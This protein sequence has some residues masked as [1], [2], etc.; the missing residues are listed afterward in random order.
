MPGITPSQ[1]VGPYYAYGLTPAGRYAWNDAFSTNL[2][3]PD[4]VGERI[5][6]E[7]T[8]V[9]GDGAPIPDA[10]IEIWQADA[11][12]RYVTRGEDGTKPNTSF[13]GFGRCGTDN[14]GGF[15][16]D[17]IKPGP[18]AGPDGKMQAPHILVAYF[19]RGL[20]THLYTRIYFDGEA[21]NA[22]DPV[23]SLVPTERRGTLIAK[24]ASDGAYR[25]D[26]YMQ[27]ERETVFFA[28]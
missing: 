14:N 9:D 11:Q 13:R 6:I 15:R 18:V 2:A 3:T 22:S 4:A 26:I 20:L 1:T 7:G 19:S 25:F 27:G 8:V 28:V 17:T 12:G 10:M 5:R 16:F 24:K 21:A 23:L